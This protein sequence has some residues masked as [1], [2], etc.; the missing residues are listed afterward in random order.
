ME[1][2]TFRIT[3][4]TRP[5]NTSTRKIHTRQSSFTIQTHTMQAPVSIETG[6]SG[7]IEDLF[8]KPPWQY[9]SLYTL[10]AESQAVSTRQDQETSN[11]R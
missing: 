1:P 2:S 6:H 10:R 3:M 4:Y 11:K 5:L 9:Y 8:K 7:Q